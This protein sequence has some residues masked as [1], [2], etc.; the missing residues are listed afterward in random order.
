MNDHSYAAGI[1]LKCSGVALPK[2]NKTY[3]NTIKPDGYVEVK[4]P[5]G[6]IIH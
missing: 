5:D 2:P 4:L 6:V 1:L 3:D